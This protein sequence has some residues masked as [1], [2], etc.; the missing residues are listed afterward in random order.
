MNFFPPFLPCFHNTEIFLL[1]GSL[2]LANKKGDRWNKIS[3][4]ICNDTN[5]G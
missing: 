5:S 1:I 3:T 2:S 4:L